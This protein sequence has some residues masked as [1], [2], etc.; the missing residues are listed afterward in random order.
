MHCYVDPD[1]KFSMEGVYKKKHRR[2]GLEMY[3]II[4]W[5]FKCSICW[6][7]NIFCCN[8]QIFRDN[9]FLYLFIY[10]L[11]LLSHPRWVYN[12]WTYKHE[13]IKS[14]FLINTVLIHKHSVNFISRIACSNLNWQTFSPLFHILSFIYWIKTS[15]SDIFATLLAN[16]ALPRFSSSSS[17]PLCPD[18][19]FPYSFRPCV[20]THSLQTSTP[21]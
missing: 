14:V 17:L 20:Y 2:I 16:C 18:S 5:H 11:T 12:H 15:T 19:C 13:S 6:H 7:F 21:T 8:S 4:F 9:K 10:S 3:K 1:T